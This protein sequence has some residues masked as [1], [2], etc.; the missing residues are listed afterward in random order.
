M[1]WKDDLKIALNLDEFDD[2][3]QYDSTNQDHL[4]PQVRMLIDAFVPLPHSI[5]T[6][7]LEIGPGATP[8][9]DT[10]T[11]RWQYLEPSEQRA[12]LLREG[13]LAKYHPERQPDKVMVGF[14]EDMPFRNDHF[15]LVLMLNGFFQVRSDY[16]AILEINRVLRPRGRFIFNLQTGDDV[17]IIVGRVLGP[18]NTVRML[19][20]FGFEP[21]CVWEGLVNKEHRVAHGLERQA[22][23][24]VE[25]VRNAS[26]RDLN[27]PQLVG[28]LSWDDLDEA[29]ADRK[30]YIGHNID[31]EGREG[32]LA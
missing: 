15:D 26:A 32:Y 7:R 9:E 16:E 29:Y 2:Q 17:D 12:R 14:A 27:M 11:L 18:R 1:D 5:E 23:I 21:L 19:R 8:Y 28:P 30:L 24:V 20:Q 6:S 25:K 10:D 31:L 3:V 4:Y 22:V 13:V